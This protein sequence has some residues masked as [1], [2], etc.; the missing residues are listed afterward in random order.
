MT[1]SNPQ[2]EC[3]WSKPGDGS[4][5]GLALTKLVRLLARRAARELADA[6]QEAHVPKR[7]SNGQD[8]QT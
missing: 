8:P 1:R 7:L 6:A 2:T 3:P 5:A 4:D